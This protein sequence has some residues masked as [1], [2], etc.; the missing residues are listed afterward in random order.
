MR[1]KIKDMS[2]EFLKKLGIYRIDRYIIG[3]FLSTYFFLILI[4]ITIAIIFDYNEKIDKFTQSGVSFKNIILDFYLNFIPYFVNLFSPLFVFI[5]VIFFTSKLADKSEI[6]AMKAA[7]MSYKRLL[8]PYIFSA[9]LIG[10]MTFV[11]GAYIIPK[12]NV[13]RVDFE[14]T[15]LKKKKSSITE[16]VQLQVAPGVVAYITQFDNE[17][18]RGFGFSLDKFENKQLKSRL[19][20]NVINYDTLAEKRYSW[21]VQQYTLREFKGMKEEITNGAKMDT[22]IQM[23]PSDFFYINN[24]QETMTLPQLQEF[25]DKQANRGAAGVSTFEVEY[26]KR[27]ATPF[28]AII[29][30]IIGVSLSSQK[31]KGGMGT[32]IGLGLALSFTY[33]LLQSVTASFAINAGWPAMLAVWLPNILFAV[34]AFIL[35]KR[36]PQ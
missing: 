21:S 33:I 29:L 15:Y 35:Y 4:I 18:K 22:I 30:T 2:L 26:H 27:F 14:N 34:I 24:Q 25:I 1:N 36:T 8:R 17:T 32:S 7:G 19:T 12:G 5:S 28:A 31:R 23:E 20:A 10:V 13:A 6:I 9:I 11:L 16:N 3:K